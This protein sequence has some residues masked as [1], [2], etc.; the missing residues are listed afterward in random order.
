MMKEGKESRMFL[1]E[2]MDC[3]VLIWEDLEEGER[4][5]LKVLLYSTG[6]CIQYPVT[7]H[8]EKEYEKE[9]HMYN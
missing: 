5:R 3:Y 1:T 4:N 7:D 9:I 8:N 6:D 2:V